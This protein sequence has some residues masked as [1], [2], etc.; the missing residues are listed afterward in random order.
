LGFDR[1]HYVANV[2]DFATYLVQMSLLSTKASHLGLDLLGHAQAVKMLV[3]KGANISARTVKDFNNEES[4]S[5]SAL[6]LAIDN[7]HEDIALLSMLEDISNSKFTSF[8]DAMVFGVSYV[9]D[10]IK[11]GANNVEGREK[12]TEM[13]PLLIASEQGLL[14]LMELFLGNGADANA[15]DA[16]GNTS[17]HYQCTISNPDSDGS[18]RAKAAKILIDFGADVDAKD[19]SGKTPLHKCCFYGDNNGVLKLL[20]ENK[21]EIDAAENENGETALQTRRS[22]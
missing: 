8:R 14:G 21:A 9:E 20:L 13:T 4:R 16:R 19:L 10:L 6:E 22:K 3:D 18:A 15:T 5:Y 7:G 2:L 17:L 1:E 12:D 11:A